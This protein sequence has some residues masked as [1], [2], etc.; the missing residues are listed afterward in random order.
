MDAAGYSEMLVMIYQIRWGDI[1]EGSSF[2]S[3]CH[4]KTEI[5]IGLPCVW[6]QYLVTDESAKCRK[7]GTLR[8]Q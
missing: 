4:E 3:D 5:F 8:C 2:R 6:E 1:T 7:F